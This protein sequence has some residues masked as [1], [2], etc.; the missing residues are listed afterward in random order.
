MTRTLAVLT[1]LLITAG[2][3]VHAS[4]HGEVV[5]DIDGGLLLGTA[6]VGIG[7]I[8][9]GEPVPD[10]GLAPV[11]HVAHPFTLTRCDRFLA[12]D[13]LYESLTRPA[14]GEEDAIL[15]VEIQNSG[16]ETVEAWLVG[17]GSLQVATR[18]A[19]PP[20][21]YSL[22]L[23]HVAGGPLTYNATVTAFEDPAT[24]P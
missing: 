20:G 23:F 22:D 7:E 10:Q 4:G 2:P 6:G 5:L 13:V 1:V 17:D 12:V 3:V 19:Y 24:C 8:D 18:D 14:R 9:D 15:Q 11:S 21:R 16:G